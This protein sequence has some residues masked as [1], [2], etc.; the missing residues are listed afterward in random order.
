MYSVLGKRK[1]AMN[2]AHEDDAA[3]YSV[4]DRVFVIELL[5]WVICREIK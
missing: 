1:L 4:K 3:K 2:L 5:K